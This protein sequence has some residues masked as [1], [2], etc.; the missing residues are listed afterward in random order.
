MI[1]GLATRLLRS[2]DPEAAHDLTIRAL[3]AGLGPRSGPKF[4]PALETMLAGIRLPNPIGLAPGF[5]KNAEVFAPMLRAGFGFVE[6]GT[7]T[8]KPQAGNPKPRL[9]RL[10]EDQAVINRMGFNNEGLEAFAQRLERRGRGRG[11]V[12]AN[13]GANK[14][15][16]DRIAD[17]VAG[18]VRLWGLA[19]YFTINVSSPNTP[20][21]RALQTRGALEELL[22][23]VSEACAEL[24]PRGRVPVFLKVAPDLD[25]AEVE[26]I[27]ETAVAEDL[28]G[29]IVSNTTL[30]RPPL[31]SKY[32]GETGGLSGAP[33][34]EPSTRVLRQF[35]TAAEGR[36]TL[37]GVGGVGS[38]E[39]AYA[40]IRAGASAV[41]LYSAMVYQGPGL[42]PRIARDLAA[43]LKA[44]GFLTVAEAVGAG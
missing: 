20:G 4:D 2:Q 7:V 32:A 44:D 28:S 1:H 39:A 10:T 14:D 21:L 22:G 26:A 42:V 11:V 13:I 12:G 33:L 8:P 19:D 5:D 34:F 35:H 24:P 38:G 29:I 18:L 27:V 25:E 3:K 9:F 31:R 6:A 30:S 36:L 37:I 23:R 16:E 17:Y 40:K 41:Q 15:S 43:R